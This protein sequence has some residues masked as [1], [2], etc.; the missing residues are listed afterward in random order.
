M[1]LRN[2]DLIATDMD[3]DTVM[4]SVERGS[5]FGMGSVGSHAWTLLAQPTTLAEMTRAICASFD[6]D[7]SVC[8]TD[9]QKFMQEL[10]KNGLVT[11]V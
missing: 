9:L 3:G 2:P 10:L 6:V 7:E 11:R 5:Y 4:M 1:Y 8:H